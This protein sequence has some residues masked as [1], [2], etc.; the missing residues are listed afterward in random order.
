MIT[1]ALFLNFQQFSLPTATPGGDAATQDTPHGA[2]VE[3][4]RERF[5]FLTNMVMFIVYN[6]A[7][8]CKHS[9]SIQ[10]QP[11]PQ[12]SPAAPYLRKPVS[13]PSSSELLEALA[14]R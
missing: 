12:P 8:L 6:L 3:V 11:L 2:P 10:P 1:L 9:T 5:H 14:S 7:F 13:A 4:R